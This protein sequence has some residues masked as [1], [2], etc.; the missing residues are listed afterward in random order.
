MQSKETNEPVFILRGKDKF[1]PELLLKWATMV[2]LNGGSPEVARLVEN[3]AQDMIQWQKE[4]GSAII[5]TPFLSESVEYYNHV[6]EVFR[7]KNIA[8]D[9]GYNFVLWAE[10]FYTPGAETRL[11]RRIPRKSI[12][13]SYYNEFPVERKRTTSNAFMSKL[14]IYCQ[15]KGYA[16]NPH[17]PDHKKS[18]KSGGIEFLTVADTGITDN[19]DQTNVK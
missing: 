11:N 4:N 7:K 16:I 19:R 10:R 12:Q 18:D 2:R 14:S 17:L 3:T 1:A 6:M 8:D 15:R 13:A 9:L 5:D